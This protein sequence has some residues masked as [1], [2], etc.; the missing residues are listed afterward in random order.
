[1]QRKVKTTAGASDSAHPPKWIKPQLMRLV[2]EAPAGDN[3]LNEVKYDGYRMR[4]CSNAEVHRRR[5]Q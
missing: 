2:D 3:W 4:L 5:R 1:M